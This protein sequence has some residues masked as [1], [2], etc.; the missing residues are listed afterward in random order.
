[1][2]RFHPVLALAAAMA[3]SLA[4]PPAVIAVPD[5]AAQEGTKAMFATKAGLTPKWWTGL[6]APRL[7]V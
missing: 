4:A 5:P 6:K 1:M 2:S 7:S 3:S